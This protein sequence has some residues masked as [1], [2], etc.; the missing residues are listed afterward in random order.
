MPIIF[1]RAGAA[2]RATCRYAA[3][4]PFDASPGHEGNTMADAAFQARESKFGELAERPFRTL[5][6]DERQSVAFLE[7]E[8][9]IRR[10][11]S[12]RNEIVKLTSMER[13]MAAALHLEVLT[14]RLGRF[15]R[16]NSRLPCAAISSE[17]RTSANWVL[18]Q[19]RRWGTLC[20]YQKHWLESI[21]GFFLDPIGERADAQVENYTRVA[22]RVVRA[23]TRTSDD[24]EEVRAARW[25]TK[26]RMLNRQGKLPKYRVDELSKLKYW[27]WSAAGLEEG[28]PR[29]NQ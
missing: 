17:E 21:P 10:H 23:P 29:R 28:L 27:W 4:R 24:K 16:Q 9:R 15:P 13:W 1:R 14:S 19:R 7:A 8:R 22:N 26:Q 3:H 18:Y 11:D 20:S 5:N 2:V 25:A 12:Q 6:N